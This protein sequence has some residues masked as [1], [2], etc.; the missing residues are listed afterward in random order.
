MKIKRALCIIQ[1]I[2]CLL[3][4][5]PTAEARQPVIRTISVFSSNW[6]LAYQGS[7]YFTVISNF[8]RMPSGNFGVDIATFFKTD[9]NIKVVNFSYS[10]INCQS[11]LVKALGESLEMAASLPEPVRIVEPINEYKKPFVKM[12]EGSNGY[13]MVSKV[14]GRENAQKIDINAQYQRFMK[15]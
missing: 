1:S 2:W 8:T 9:D 4:I 13:S 15:K 6:Y 14:C 11:N 10:E 7:D 12:K 5:T 3:V